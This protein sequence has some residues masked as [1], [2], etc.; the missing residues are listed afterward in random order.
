MSRFLSGNFQ[1]AEK[2]YRYWL[3]LLCTGD[4]KQ[5]NSNRS[6]LYLMDSIIKHSFIFDPTFDS[7]TKV[8][9]SVYEVRRNVLLFVF[10]VFIYCKKISF[11]F[12]QMLSQAGKQNKGFFSK[13]FGDE[14]PPEMLNQNQYSNSYWTAFISIKV[15]ESAYSDLFDALNCELLRHPAQSLEQA[16]KVRIFT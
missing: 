4:L 11:F 6:T 7:V 13:I 14:P 5:W 2:F 15:E 16:F 9:L 10:Y 8:L 3:L 1:K 12:Q